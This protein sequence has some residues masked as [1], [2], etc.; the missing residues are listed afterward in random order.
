MVG[1]VSKNMFV[2]CSKQQLSTISFSKDSHGL[3]YFYQTWRRRLL[4]I[5]RSNIYDLK[6][7]AKKK[8][9]LISSYLLQLSL[10]KVLKKAWPL[11]FACSSEFVTQ[12]CCHF[13]LPRDNNSILLSTPCCYCSALGSSR[14]RHS[15]SLLS[16]RCFFH[17]SNE[18][19]A[20][21]V[22]VDKV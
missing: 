19:L 9:S 6:N 12:V 17:T 1:W 16:I 20:K 22:F 2:G 10:L 18:T 7:V 5:L 11:C 21:N 8:V 14:R 3:K 13:W 4:T 15:S